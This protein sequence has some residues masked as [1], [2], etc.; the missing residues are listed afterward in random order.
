MYSTVTCLMS[1][2]GNFSVKMIG[3]YGKT[4]WGVYINISSD[5]KKDWRLL[6]CFANRDSAMVYFRTKN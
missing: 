3:L 1:L 2:D 6:R 4:S 5:P